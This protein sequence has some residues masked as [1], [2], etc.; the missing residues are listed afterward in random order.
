MPRRSSGGGVNAE[1]KLEGLAKG[2]LFPFYVLYGKERYFVQRAVSLLKQRILPPRDDGALL[3]HSVYGQELSGVELADLA[4]SE[5]FFGS[6]QLVVVWDAEKIKEKAQKEIQGYAENPAPFTRMVFVAG[7]ESPKGTLFALLKKSQPE[8][9]LEFPGLKRPEYHKWVERMA[10]E[11]GLGR[12][13]PPGLLEGLLSGGPVPLENLDKQLEILALYLQDVEG[14]KITEP[15]PFGLP[16]VSLEQSYRF[17]D[18]LLEGELP[19]AL[20]IL[21]R[22]LN[23]GAPPLMIL[24]RIVWE[25]RKIWQFK[26]EMDRGPISDSFLRSVRIQP[27]KKTTYA[28]LARRLSWGALGEVFFSL[29]DTDRLLKSSRVDP[30]FHLEALCQ[31]ITGLVTVKSGYESGGGSSTPR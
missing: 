30:R 24:S 31:G 23:Q 21:N 29:G 11:K 15:M 3:Y 20:D 8:A 18:C 25:F 14:D 9:C 2:D 13:A 1:K 10:R 17:T 28:S 12:K 16:E 7:Q 4:R 27:F 6:T 19:D 26:E 22:Y 5:P